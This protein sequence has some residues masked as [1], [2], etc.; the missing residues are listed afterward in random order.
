[1]RTRLKNSKN[2]NVSIKGSLKQSHKDLFLNLLVRPNNCMNLYVIF[3]QAKMI[4]FK[5]AE[6]S[7]ISMVVARPSW[8]I[9]EI[10]EWPDFLVLIT[11]SYNDARLVQFQPSPPKRTAGML[12]HTLVMVNQ[13][14]PYIA[15]H[16]VGVDTQLGTLQPFGTLGSTKKI[17]VESPR[18]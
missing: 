2:I 15:V 10:R 5:M 14:C 9:F 18:P 1:M 11:R 17:T 4:S 12:I 8:G 3:I 7:Y 6:N 16:Y 13:M